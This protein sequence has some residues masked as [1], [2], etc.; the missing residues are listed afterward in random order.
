M[1]RSADRHE[2]WWL[3]FLVTYLIGYVDRAWRWVVRGAE[4]LS[5]VA[6]LR[7]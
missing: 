4:L 7:A 6:M 2:A 5:R 1:L 3:T